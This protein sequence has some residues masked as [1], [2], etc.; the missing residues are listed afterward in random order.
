MRTA[1]YAVGL[2]A[3]IALT[4]T[5][6]AQANLQPVTPQGLV[7]NVSI[8]SP[9]GLFYL[10]TVYNASNTLAKASVFVWNAS[11]DPQLGGYKLTYGDLY[12]PDTN[13]I[14]VPKTSTQFA[15]ASVLATNTVYYFFVTATN[16]AGA[17]SLPSNTVVYQP[18]K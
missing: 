15:F 16:T 6:F 8:K 5:G 18:E 17:E 3:L 2:L 10:C 12:K 4:F 11:P 9:N 14:S 1:K 13:V 7:T